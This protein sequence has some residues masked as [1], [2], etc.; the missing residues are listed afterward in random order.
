MP[1]QY[2]D[3]PNPDALPSHI[4]DGVKDLAVKFGRTK[5]DDA[6]DHAIHKFRRAACYIAAGETEI[7]RFLC[8]K[9]IVAD[10]H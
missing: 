6:S 1:G 10:K 3:K 9:A 4:P 8:C 7:G 5:V 2:I